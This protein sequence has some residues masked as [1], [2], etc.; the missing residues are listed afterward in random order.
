LFDAASRGDAAAAARVL[1]TDAVAVD[2]AP[3]FVWSGKNGGMRWFTDEANALKAG[4]VTLRITMVGSAR[5]VTET[6][7]GSALYFAQPIRVALTTA[8][9]TDYEAGIAT[10]T[11]RKERSAW[12]ITSYTWTM[13]P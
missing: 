10:M 2:D 4:H 8:G 11:M 6:T 13:K 3:P 12:K 5:E 7:D 1:S 9:K